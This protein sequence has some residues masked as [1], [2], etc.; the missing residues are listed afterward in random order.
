LPRYL[1]D[2]LVQVVPLEVLL[3]LLDLLDYLEVLL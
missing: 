2:L 1:P 3:F